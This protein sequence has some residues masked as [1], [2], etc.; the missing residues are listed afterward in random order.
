MN[1]PNCNT[2]IP[3]GSRFCDYC[4]TALPSIPLR[5]SAA[6]RHLEANDNS[7][8]TQN[9]HNDNST[10]IITTKHDRRN[11][12][13]I[14][15]G[16]V[17]VVALFLAFVIGFPFFQRQESV[18]IAAEASATEAARAAATE[19]RLFVLATETAV[20]QIA[21]AAYAPTATQQALATRYAQ[22][23]AASN[24]GDWKLAYASFRDVFDIDPNYED[25]Q[26]QIVAVGSKLTPTATAI[27]TH[28]P[29]PTSTPIP[30]DTPVPPSPTTTA[31]PTPVPTDTA[32]ATATSTPVPTST[33]RLST[34]TATPSATASPTATPL[35]SS[36]NTPQITPAP[37]VTGTQGAENAADPCVIVITATGVGF[38][39]ES[40]STVA[41]RRNLAIRAADADGKR[42][43]AEWV[44]GVDIEAV[45]VVQ[46]GVVEM[47]VIRQIVSAKLK[48]V[49]T[50]SQNYNDTTGEAIVELTL[51][52]ECPTS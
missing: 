8:A 15:F 26:A 20:A 24:I 33:P 39:P 31:T 34:A 35:P 48:G 4:N 22:G 41:Q 5:P 7:G 12:G 14:L 28:T 1:C 21:T 52:I 38:P 16:F 23:V 51:T 43:L 37:P 46:D 13:L 47:D 45:T 27:P 3:D 40:A 19:A 49:E 18:R 6:N 2:S 9:S 42:K 25:V 30:S 44:S 29:I 50:T 32:T 11:S 10:T 36:T 17:V